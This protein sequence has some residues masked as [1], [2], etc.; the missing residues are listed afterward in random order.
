MIKFVILYTSSTEHNNI[1]TYII[2]PHSNTT[3]FK[4]SE[5]LIIGRYI[6]FVFIIIILYTKT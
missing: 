2:V 4:N 1:Q 6:Y 3:Y 5:H